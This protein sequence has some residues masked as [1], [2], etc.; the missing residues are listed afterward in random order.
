MNIFRFIGRGHKITLTLTL[1][2][3]HIANCSFV[4]NSIECIQLRTHAF[5]IQLDYATQ[6]C[7]QD[8]SAPIS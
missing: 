7:L 5:T 3:F 1:N 4:A 2:A 6:P 8:T